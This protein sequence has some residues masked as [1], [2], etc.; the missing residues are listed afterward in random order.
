MHFGHSFTWVS[1]VWKHMNKHFKLLSPSCKLQ[2]FE[3]VK[4]GTLCAHLLC[5]QSTGMCAVV[6]FCFFFTKC[7]PSTSLACIILHFSHFRFDNIVIRMLNFKIC[8]GKTLFFL[9]HCCQSCKNLMPF[10][11]KS[12]FKSHVVHKIPKILFGIKQGKGNIDP[13]E[14]VYRV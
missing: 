3:F 6:F 5:I 2:K 9:I 8:K 13:N 11:F 4:I 7:L 10:V 14:S 1:G 12:N